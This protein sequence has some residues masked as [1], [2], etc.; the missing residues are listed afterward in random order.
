[1]FG[2]LSVTR[3]SICAISWLS[4]FFCCIGAAGQSL[5]FKHFTVENGLSSPTALTITQDKKGFLWVGTHDGLNRYD[6]NE[7][8]VYR[9]FYKDNPA[10]ASLKILSLTVDEK[11]QLWIG[12]SNGL[13][14]YNE[15]KDTFAVFFHSRDNKKSICSNMIHRVVKDDQGGIWLCTKGGLCKVIAKDQSYSFIRI[16]LDVDKPGKANEVV[17]IADVGNGTMLAGT[18]DGAVVFSRPD[19]AG[20]VKQC[21]RILKGIRV[22]SIEKDQRQNFWLGTD[23]DG[24]IKMDPHFK[25][26]KHYR[27][28]NKNDGILGDVVWRIRTDRLGHV[29]IGTSKGLNVFFPD[30]EKMESYVFNPKDEHSLNSNFILDIFEGRQGTIWLATFF[31]GLD[32]VDAVTTPFKVY[33]SDEGRRSI[34][35]NIVSAIVEDQYHNLWIG[36]DG[37]GVN[38]YDRHKQFF[39][40]YKNHSPYTGLLKRNR[41]MSLLLDK[42]GHLWV[43]LFAEGAIVFDSAGHKWKKFG[44]D[45]ENR[46]NSVNVT[47]FMQD[48]ENRIW[49][50]TEYGIHIY[51]DKK[52]NKTFEDIY[53]GKKLSDYQISCLFEDSKRNIWIG[54]RHGLSLLQYANNSFASFYQKESADQ[55]PSD[56]IN[57]IAEDAKG[58]MWIGTYAGLCSYDP[59]QKKFR[60]YTIKDG[61][62]GNKVVG[63]VADEQDNLWLSTDNGI[64]RLDKTRKNFNTFNAYDGL[65]GNVFYNRSCF[66]DSRGHIFFGSYSGLVEFD[67]KAIEMNTQ[68]PGVVLT[69]LQIEGQAVNPHDSSGILS[70]NIS[71]INNLVLPYNKDVFAIDYAVMN[72]IKPEKNRSAY[73]LA[74]YDKNWVYAAGHKATFTNIPTGTYSLL[75]KAANN[76]GY[77]NNSP[78][79]LKLT[80]LPPP[81]K[82][83]WAYSL[84][85]LGVSLLV[86]GVAYFFTARAAFKR[87]LH[88]E[89]VANQ[90]QQEIHKMKMDFFTHISHEI[91]TPLTLI[92]LPLETLMDS[93]E[94]DKRVLKMLAKIKIN[95]E[96]L[97]TLTNHLLDF[98]KA[99]SGHTQLKISEANIV[100]FA[101]VV[102]KKFSD[103]AAQKSIKYQFKS[104]ESCISAYFDP[105]HLE[106][107]L[108]NLL[109]NAIKFTPDEGRISVWVG[110][111]DNDNVEIQVC[112]DGIGI[113]KESQ[114]Q[115][116]NN[117][118]QANAGGIKNSG[119]GIGLAFSKSLMDLHK[120]KLSFQSGVDPESGKRETR[121]IITLQ[122][123]KNHFKE[124]Y[125][126][127]D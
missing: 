78:Y 25:E 7:M 75:I 94:T 66:K 23:G 101:Q 28:G 14:L 119:S 68:A 59:V 24:V 70:K 67:P 108:S 47:C 98:R 113:P 3:W 30:S 120:G 76:D 50:G 55:L 27:Q 125:L 91:R 56:Y 62:S 34:S 100:A 48:Y 116:F 123:G 43:G 40:K 35:S 77:W 33:K 20:K 84:Y 22:I 71:E 97:L 115:I 90:K 79:V 89:Q 12:T 109:S 117:F 72:F 121:F 15:Q 57:C 37:E 92:F 95:A 106:I 38:Y 87:K 83:W 46:L 104:D 32:Y 69:G 18:Q 111:I 73:M 53:P 88:Y 102:F 11:N 54:T 10:A 96:R 85:A 110:R 82:T 21:R 122:L 127:M 60:T 39:K 13:Y 126:I 6:G 31:G 36:T 93:F 41:V 2:K 52:G 8:K 86:F 81:W 4:A 118:Y 63:I 124:S 16:K 74:G 44:P 17:A 64:T 45:G 105:H 26:L 5:R 65:P 19:D 1:M 112:D 107:V 29:W 42:A 103:A 114:D 99:D 58:I 9:H 61:L 49:I 80:I 51:D